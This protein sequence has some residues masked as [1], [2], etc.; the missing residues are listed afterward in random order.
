MSSISTEH[1]RHYAPGNI[2]AAVE[3]AL[4]AL[5]KEHALLTTT[6]LEGMDQFHSGG[7][8]AT[9]RLAERTA[10]TASD[11]VLDIGG[12]LGG[13]ARV[14]AQEIG[15][16]VTVIDLTE[17][18]CRVGEKLTERA[19]LSDR[20]HFYQGNALD[21]PFEDGSFDVVWTQHSLMNV[22]DKTRLYEQIYRV[23]RTG[24]RLVQH[25]VTA[26]SGEPLRFPVPWAQ[27]ETTSFLQ[28]Q[29]AFRATVVKAG[30]REVEW[31]DISQWT[32]AWFQERLRRQ[33]NTATG[34]N[35]LG[36]HLLIGP[37][38]GVM[39]R[40]FMLNTQEGRIHVIQGVFDRM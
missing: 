28:S 40:N 22:A 26:G 27:S 4:A 8:A 20:V 10:I 33:Q 32:L 37:N 24:G 35:G 2:D 31:K 1:M 11:R 13:S 18:Y 21:L 16:N 6:D 34:A 36:L 23:L 15:C 39:S 29:D 12:G 14:L 7:L 3:A 19:N 5:G 30:F 17:A 25:E 38:V 9:R